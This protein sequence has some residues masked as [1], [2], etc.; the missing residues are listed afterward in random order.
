[1][2]VGVKPRQST[3]W[4]SGYCNRYTQEASQNHG[5]CRID[6]WPAGMECHC[7]CHERF[8]VAF[9]TW[10]GIAQLEQGFTSREDVDRMLHVMIRL[11]L[12]PPDADTYVELY[13]GV[14]L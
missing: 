11:G 6:A 8:A 1:M 7:K 3:E 10:D 4:R 2:T 13:R 9:M 14:S 12:I 5:A